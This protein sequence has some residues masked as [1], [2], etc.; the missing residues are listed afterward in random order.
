M[1]GK[2]KKFMATQLGNW[3]AN[4]VKVEGVRDMFSM[5][6][7]DVGLQKQ[8]RSFQQ[9]IRRN[10]WTTQSTCCC[11]FSDVYSDFEAPRLEV[12]T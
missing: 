9:T 4:R 12:A 3:N 8:V 5:D 1:N 10:K 11:R 7:E 2:Q 6:V